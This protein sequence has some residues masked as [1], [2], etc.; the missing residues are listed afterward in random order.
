M[1]LSVSIEDKEILKGL[2]LTVNSGE[3]HAV[4]GPNGSG[5][6]TLAYAIAGHLSYKVKSQKSKVKIGNKE[7]LKL[8]AD[9]RAREGIFLA[10][11]NPVSIPGV[12]PTNLLRTA[13][14]IKNKTGVAKMH[15]PIFTKNTS[16][17]MD[18]INGLKTTAKELS[19]GEEFLKR[20][21]N[22]GFSGGEKKKMEMLQAISLSP[23]F[24]I[25]DEIDTGLDVD[26]LKAVA[27]GIKKLK[28]QGT[29]IIIITHYL[30]ILRYI[31]PDF[32]HI[33]VDGKIVK[34]GDFTLARKIEKEGYTNFH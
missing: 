28:S 23:K 31:K 25:F 20:G 10:F 27:N 34:S 16:Q 12:T 1:N 30:R 7:I 2:D 24:A 9:E 32:V 19:L 33:L 22:D 14:N 15:N 26:A 18:F 13:F 29:G 11:Q 3:I 17:M 21:I 6:S 8:K 4:M 5:K